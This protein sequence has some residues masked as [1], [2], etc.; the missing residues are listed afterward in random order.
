MSYNIKHLIASHHN[1]PNVFGAKLL[2]PTSLL[3]P[4]WRTLLS[5]YSN[6]IVFDFLSYGWP[7]DCT[8][9]TVPVH[10]YIIIF[11]L[12]TLILMCNYQLSWNAIAGPFKYP[13]FSNDFVCSPLQTV[14][15]RGSS[16]RRVVMDL[17][18]PSGCSVMD[19][20][21]LK[22][23]TCIWVNIISYNYP[24]LTGLS[25]SSLRKVVTVLFSRKTLRWAYRQFPIDSKDYHLL[26]FSLSGQIL[27]WHSLSF[28]KFGEHERGL[29]GT[30]R[31]TSASWMLSKLPKCS[32]S[33][34]MHS[35]NM[36][37]R[38]NSCISRTRV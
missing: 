25:N 9:S 15:K 33:R 38:K 13:P 6:N 22:I 26:G 2:V 36:N 32:I 14:P 27:F 37:Y 19:G 16:T 11:L 20:I 28:W 29:R 31:V 4:N 8:A 12:Q 7:I 21:L 10:H 35:W 30:P 1:Q 3:L 34:Q 5:N 18:F 24:G 17:S 23:L